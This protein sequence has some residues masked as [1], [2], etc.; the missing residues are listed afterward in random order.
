MKKLSHSLLSA[1]QS[2]RYWAETGIGAVNLLAIECA[3]VITL[4]MAKAKE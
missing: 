1:L 4:C 3:A 2:S